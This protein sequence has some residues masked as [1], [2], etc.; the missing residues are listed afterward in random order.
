MLRKNKI[1][2][3]KK[4]LPGA[5]ELMKSALPC[6]CATS[7]SHVHYIAFPPDT[8]HALADPKQDTQL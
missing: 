2:K 1:K 6:T 7:H 8:R 4:N 5:T 3:K